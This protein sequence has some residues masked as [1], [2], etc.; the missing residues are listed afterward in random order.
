MDLPI[1]NGIVIPQHE[2]EITASRSGGPGG[3]HVNKTS[4]RITIRW[5]IPKSS[6]FTDEQKKR[7][8]EKLGPE[9]TIEGD[10]LVS[11][12]E[13]R[14]QHHNKALALQ[15]LAKKLMKALFVP[16]RR[17]KTVI[18][19]VKKEKRLEEKRRHSFLKRQR[20]DIED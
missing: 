5:N 13:S 16:K 7:L 9:L 19:K 6:A 14:S 4:S 20:R 12:S 3:Q 8:L 17:M 11:N 15:Q 18:S 2:L 1:K 10:L